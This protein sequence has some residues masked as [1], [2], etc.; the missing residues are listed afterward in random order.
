MI[1]KL[2]LGLTV[3]AV[4]IQATPEQ[5]STDIED[6]AVMHPRRTRPTRNPLIS[7]AEFES[8]YW[9]NQAQATLRAK[10]ARELNKNVAKNVIMFLGDGLSI[11]TLKAARVWLGQQRG[12]DGEATKLAMEEFP[13]AG[14]SKTYCLDA[15]TA[16]SACSATA[17][18]AGV[19]TNDGAIGV[20]GKSVNCNTNLDVS[21]HVFSIAKW[22]QDVGKKTGIVT[23]TRVTHASP[24]GKFKAILH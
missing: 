13:Y 24:A 1:R 15:Q 10:R 19:K 12:E 20:N 14:L 23:T 11:G 18:L 6:D 5:P 7:E 21:N 22:S 4:I 17:Y 8:D 3:I 16:D 2:L 9:I